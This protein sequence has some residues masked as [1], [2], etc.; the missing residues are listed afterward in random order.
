MFLVSTFA[1]ERFI[2]LTSGYP[3][4]VCDVMCLVIYTNFIYHINFAV[5]TELERL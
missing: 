3:G 1:S 2:L 4:F 5:G